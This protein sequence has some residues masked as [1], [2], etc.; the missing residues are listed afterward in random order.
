MLS[1]Y[2][3]M[4]FET[5]VWTDCNNFSL[6]TSY[7]LIITE[8]DKIN[9]SPFI[10]FIS[11]P[12]ACMYRDLVKICDGTRSSMRSI[13][14]SDTPK[15]HRKKKNCFNVIINALDF[16]P[17]FVTVI[18]SINICWTPTGYCSWQT[19]CWWLLA[20]SKAKSYRR[21]RGS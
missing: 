8:P 15:V 4:V 18:H 17:D 21:Y 5:L 19:P 3:C 13:K 16:L 10:I 20:E 11:V 2:G 12:M 6:Q 9:T 7:F 14:A 1:C